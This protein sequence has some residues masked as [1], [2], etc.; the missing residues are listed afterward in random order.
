M[1]D[2]DDGADYGDDYYDEDDGGMYDGM[3]I[4]EEAK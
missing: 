2:Y 4:E 3:E 1:S